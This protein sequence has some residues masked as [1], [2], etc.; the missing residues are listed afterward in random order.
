[1]I[2]LFKTA[3]LRSPTGLAC[4]RDLIELYQQRSEVEY[5]PGLEPDKCNPISTLTTIGDIYT[6]ATRKSKAPS[7]VCAELCSVCP[8]NQSDQTSNRSKPVWFAWHGM[9]DI[10]A[11]SSDAER[12]FS[13]AGEITMKKRNHLHTDLPLS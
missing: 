13:D 9:H 10:P 3:Q 6:G 12:T 4:L 1:M 2:D 11:M 5:R 7:M 8:T